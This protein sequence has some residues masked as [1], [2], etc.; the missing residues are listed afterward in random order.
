[1]RIEAFYQIPFFS[2]IF[3]IFKVHNPEIAGSYYSFTYI[4][5]TPLTQASPILF[6]STPCQNILRSKMFTKI[7]NT[8]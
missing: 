2:F 5:I 1:M 7:L 4:S 8:N 6:M 3:L